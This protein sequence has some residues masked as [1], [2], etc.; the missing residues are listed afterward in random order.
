VNWAAFW[1][2]C[3]WRGHTPIRYGHGN[4]TLAPLYGPWFCRCCDDGPRVLRPS[5]W[6]NCLDC[7]SQRPE[8][9]SGALAALGG[10]DTK[11]QA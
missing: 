4:G 2:V 6:V 9:A 10:Q 5:Y 7:G 3:A 8:R 1:N 11:G